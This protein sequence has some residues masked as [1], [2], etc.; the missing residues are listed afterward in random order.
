MT[1]AVLSIGSNVGDRLANLQSVVDGLGSAAV[2][3]S[4]V[5]RTAPWGGVV[6]D[7]F[8]NAVVLVEDSSADGHVWLRRGRALEDAARRVREVRWGPR[9]LDVDIVDC[10]GT[11]SD[12]PDLTLPHPRA[13]ERAFVL[14]PWLDVDPDATLDGEPVAALLAALP[15]A[16]R[17]GV[18]ATDF[19]LR[20]A[21]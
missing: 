2:A 6:Q 10:G 16:E 11:R 1:R 8:L 12:D 13:R 14:L 20:L 3:V 19:V 4:R 7:D 15:D 17:A 9:T 18:S 5:Y 21:G